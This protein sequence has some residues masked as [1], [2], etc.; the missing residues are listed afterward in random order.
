[1]GKKILLSLGGDYL[2]G[3]YQV[4]GVT[5]GVAFAEWLWGAYGPYNQTW[6]D[7]NPE[8][9]IRP[10]DRGLYNTD[11]SSDYQIDIDGFDFD[12]ERAPTG[13]IP[14]YS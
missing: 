7:L 3:P 2:T 14:S 4:T 8:A 12:I 13:M 10:F 1:M 5:E 6:I 9:N 11:P